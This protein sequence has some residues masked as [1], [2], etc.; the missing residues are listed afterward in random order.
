M[1]H[2]RLNTNGCIFTIF[3]DLFFRCVCAPQPFLSYVLYALLGTVGLLTHYLL[4]Q[5]RKQLPWYCFSHPLLK[6]KEYYQFEVRGKYSGSYS[7]ENSSKSNPKCGDARKSLTVQ[8]WWFW[9]HILTSCAAETLTE[10][11]WC[12]STLPCVT[13]MLTFSKLVSLVRCGSCDVVWKASCVAAV[14]GEECPVSTRHP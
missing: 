6:T 1:W 2:H 4:P 10:D 7:N 3:N 12:L 13:V 8:P 5:F 9:T 14:C 11:S